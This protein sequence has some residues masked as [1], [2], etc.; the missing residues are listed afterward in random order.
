MIGLPVPPL[1]V[2]KETI[3]NV[4]AVLQSA[5]N[6][7]T[8][9]VRALDELG[10]LHYESKRLQAMAD[11]LEQAAQLLSEITT[12]Q[13]ATVVGDRRPQTV[14]DTKRHIEMWLRHEAAKVRAAI[15]T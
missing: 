4:Q 12:G 3:L 7:G 1:R 5:V 15:V 14:L 6:R 8:D 11:T 9:P 10:L 13:L 2:D